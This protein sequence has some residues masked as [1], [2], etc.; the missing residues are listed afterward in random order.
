MGLPVSQIE[1]GDVVVHKPSGERWL[2]WGVDI[3]GRRFDDDRADDARMD[4][5]WAL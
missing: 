1:A 2:V 5:E 4:R 3:A